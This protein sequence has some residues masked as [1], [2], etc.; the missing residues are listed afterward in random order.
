LDGQ[1]IGSH[2]FAD[3]FSR[4]KDAAILGGLSNFS[5]RPSA[6]VV[7][8]YNVQPVIDIY[9]AVQGRDLG[10]V[11]RDLNRVLDEAAKGAPWGTHVV[12]RGQVQTMTSA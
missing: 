4:Y 10:A 11:S 6:A 1:P 7:S 9:G 12:V 3:N 5:P 8:H 2:Q